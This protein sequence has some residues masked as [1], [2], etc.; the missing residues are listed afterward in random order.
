MARSITLDEANSVI[1]AAIAK[2]DE[3][4]DEDEHRRR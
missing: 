3:Q 4:E 1:A 2:A